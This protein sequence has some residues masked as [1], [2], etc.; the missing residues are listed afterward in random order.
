[1]SPLELP[2]TVR[3]SWG[4]EIAKD[5][6]IWLTAQ[7]QAV[8]SAPSFQISASMARRKVNTLVLQRVSNLLLA[9]EPTLKQLSTEEWVW[10]VPV[11][12]TFPAHGRVGRVGEID[13]DARYGEV[14][15]TA[16]LLEKMGHDCEQLAKQM[17]ITETVDNLR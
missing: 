5:F 1:M 8:K 16:A 15:Y 10:R 17:L 12:L 7:L 11:D 6:T 13:V 3:E 9:D 14:R 4:P 2:K